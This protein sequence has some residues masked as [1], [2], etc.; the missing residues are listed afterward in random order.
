MLRGLIGTR[1][2]AS[3]RGDQSCVDA[4]VLGSTGCWE[5]GRFLVLVSVP[6]EAGVEDYEGI[7]RDEIERFSL[8]ALKSVVAMRLRW[9]CGWCCRRMEG[10]IGT[11]LAI[12]RGSIDARELKA[13]SVGA[14]DWNPNPEIA[15]Y[16]PYHQGSPHLPPKHDRD[17]DEDEKV[18]N[19]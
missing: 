6:F 4:T 5:G 10:R 8:N 19:H 3:S 13:R 17:E 12:F 18:K 16:S 9:W 1:G 14:G 11:E 7:L 2:L 15:V